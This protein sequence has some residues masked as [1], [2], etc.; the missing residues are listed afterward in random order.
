MNRNSL[1]SGLLVILF[2]GTSGWLA[3]KVASIHQAGEAGL[4]DRSIEE[5]GPRNGINILMN[6][7]SLDVAD[8]LLAVTARS[9]GQLNS[10][11]NRSLHSYALY[12]KASLDRD[13]HHA[14][15]REALPLV[16]SNYQTFS[17]DRESHG[18]FLLDF[19]SLSLQEDEYSKWK[20]DLLISEPYLE[21]Q[22]DIP[23]YMLAMETGSRESIK[24]IE[25][26]YLQPGSTDRNITE[27]AFIMLCLT[28]RQDEA[29]PYFIPIHEKYLSFLNVNLIKSNVQE[30]DVYMYISI[31]E[32][33]LHIGEFQTASLFTNGYTAG[34]LDQTYISSY[35][36]LLIA[37]AGN[38]R[39][40]EFVNLITQI[41]ESPFRNTS[42]SGERARIFTELYQLTGN[43]NWKELAINELIANETDYDVNIVISDLLLDNAGEQVEITLNSEGSH[44]LDAFLLAERSLKLADDQSQINDAW[45]QMFACLASRKSQ[46]GRA[47]TAEDFALLEMALSLDTDSATEI[48]L[49]AQVNLSFLA[50]DDRL[51][52]FRE[53]DT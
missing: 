46:D 38:H 17:D 12:Y 20:N 29:A 4:A 36:A 44:S 7:P 22:L 10:P 27:N 21:K 14:A 32:Y 19:I 42:M 24:S 3:W 53:Q 28:G 11:E 26:K 16:L 2:V 49:A 5:I 23:H 41:S 43:L 13:H 52:S 51:T 31:L 25:D 18:R 33:L 40:G 35:R 9:L 37:E 15:I 30:L 47:I 39:S 8:E 34:F 45:L 50:S 1:I 48:S 6:D